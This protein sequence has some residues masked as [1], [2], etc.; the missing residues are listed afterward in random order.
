VISPHSFW[1]LCFFP[2]VDFDVLSV[3]FLASGKCAPTEFD[4]EDA[5]CIDSSLKCNNRVNC[6]FRTDE[7]DKC[8]VSFIPSGRDPGES[9]SFSYSVIEFFSTHTNMKI[10]NTFLCFFF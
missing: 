5:L 2:R 9:S 8:N 1:L 7:D 4:C 3:G 10:G 6:K